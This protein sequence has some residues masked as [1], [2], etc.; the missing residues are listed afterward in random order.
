MIGNTN[1]DVLVW[2]GSNW[3]AGTDQTADGDTDPNNELELPTSAT[4]GEVLMWNGSNW[5]AGTDQ[6]A[7]G[8]TDATNEL[9]LPMIGNTIGDVLV[10]NGTN[11]VNQAPTV[12]SDNQDLDLSGNT[13]SLTNDATPVDL[14]PYL[15]NTDNQTLTATPSPGSILLDISGGNSVVLGIDD[16]DANPTN[17][18]QNLSISNDTLFIS[19]GNNV[20]LPSGTTYFPGN[21]ISFSGDTIHNIGDF[22]S[23]PTNESITGFGLNGGND[24]LEIIESGNHWTVPLS[25]LSDGNG[26]YSGSGTVPSNITVTQNANNITY[27]G[28]GINPTAIFRNGNVLGA[29]IQIDATNA[30]ASPSM[31]L[32]NNGTNWGGIS[33]T[34]NGLQLNGGTGGNVGIGVSPANGRF[35]VQH[36]ATAAYPTIKLNQTDLNLNRV[37]FTNTPVANK[38]WEIAAETDAND[39]NAG[40]SINYYN[41]STYNIHFLTYGNGKTA[42]NGSGFVPAINSSMFDVFGTTTIHDSLSIRTPHGSGYTFPVV[43][44]S[45]NYL[46]QTD[47]SGNL[48][49]VDPSSLG[50]SGWS[51]TGNAG[52]GVTNFIGTTDAQDLRFR[53]NNTE[54]MVIT[55]SGN[56]GIGVTA[57]LAK[58]H[59][60]EDGTAV[61]GIM[62]AGSYSELTLLRSNGPKASPSHVLNNDQIGVV[63]FVGY[64]AVQGW[65]GGLAASITVTATENYSASGFKGSKM[66][67]NVSQNGGAGTLQAMTIDNFGKV[68]IGTTS[69]SELL[70][71][72]GNN[73][74]MLINS[75]SGHSYL[76]INSAPTAESGIQLQ[77]NNSTVWSIY[78]PSNTNDLRFYDGGFRVT[79][80]S[81]GNVGIGTTNPMSLLHLERNNNPVIYM[82]ET[83]PTNGASVI[84]ESFNQYMLISNESGFFRI[85]NNTSTDSPFNISSTGLVGINGDAQ[86]S[87]LDVHGQITMRDGAIN[88]YIP[89]SDGN[90]T[91]TWTNPSTL[92]LG[93]AW[94]SSGTQ[95][96]LNNINDKVGI[97]LN[98]PSEELHIIDNISL[99]P[100]VLLETTA[101]NFAIGYRYKTSLAEWF[102]GQ[103]EATGQQFRIIDVFNN[104]VTMAIS[105]NT[106]N[107]GI[108][109]TTA[110][111][112]LTVNGDV[113]LNDGATVASNNAV[114]ILLTNSGPD[115]NAGD[116]VIVGTSDNSF[117]VTNNPGHY[118]V[119][120]VATESI[121]NGAVGK[122]AISGIVTVNIESASNVLRGQHCITGSNNGRAS[123]VSIPSAGT[124][125][126]V[127]LTNG[128]ADGTAKVLLR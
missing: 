37:H 78:K 76:K 104:K 6:T 127:Y 1:G 110:K 22:D 85:Q 3:V 119:I 90:G 102:M 73:P 32:T 120:G 23:N 108:G 33:G 66:A 28:G 103:E 51:L 55:Q 64:N 27:V 58:L 91:M 106:G 118:A 122:I 29:K 116:I 50:N 75:T 105:P 74:N 38:Y 57:P 97:G 11:W 72:Q 44:G 128:P 89:V 100:Q 5:A 52:T 16:A 62:S 61:A 34:S 31:N 95:T 39:N 53:T 40:Y 121:G 84:L 111:S 113:G 82:R 124:S 56:V 88:G 36:A 80:Q 94:T 68:G 71:I 47:G 79:F 45:P 98:N 67:F 107:V 86:F 70:E 48:S 92:G 30:G 18:L 7:D 93:G 115:V 43:D 69:P 87:E 65:A 101:G 35:V 112:T 96:Y 59:I 63:D 19:G 24:S 9:E 10:W 46:M 49:W 21:G 99:R 77:A 42:I 25:D 8:D 117:N 54:K 83:T 2:N 14:S 41:G 126:G 17:E 26:I 15:D 60:S 114:T 12:G 109:T 4:T 13:L 123:G 81:G 20:T 125:I